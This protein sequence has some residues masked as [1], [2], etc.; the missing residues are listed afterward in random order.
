VEYGVCADP[1]IV[2][3]AIQLNRQFFTVVGV[4][5][6][7]TYGAL[8]LRI[9][10][11]A[12][13]NAARLLV[14]S[15]TRNDNE[16]FLWLNLIG[17]QEEGASLAQV[18]AE[19]DVIAAQID[20]RQSGRSTTLTIERAKA[21]TVPPGLRGLATA[22]AAVL[23]A[24]FGCILLIAC[25]NVANMLL[26]WGTSR[27]NEIGIRLSLGASRARI[28]RQLVTE[29]LLISLAGGLL[30]SVVGL[31]LFQTLV[32]LAVPALAPPDLPLSLTW[33]MN[34]DVQV[35]VFAVVLTLVTGILVGLAPALQVSRPDLH[36]VMK[37]DTAGAGT[38]QRGT[39][40]R[41]TLVGV[42]VALCM[43]LMMTAG[44]LLRGLYTT[45][46]HVRNR[47]GVSISRRLLR[48]AGVRAGRLHPR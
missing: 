33:N 11:F 13:I 1:G 17:R 36:A 31:W 18:R 21:M 43:T 25:A 16:K 7:G 46:Y 12:P 24:A 14:S 29:S 9:G 32:A 28:V 22:V 44:L 8:F 47:P 38:S 27:S 34:P 37:Q 4:A 23:M 3:R 20:R 48:I 39:R 40:M 19:L 42:Q 26:A 10:Y 45:V 41:G 30:G 15:D 35:V 6:E 2:G 5:A